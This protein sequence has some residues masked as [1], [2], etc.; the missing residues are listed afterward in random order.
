M[1]N[2]VYIRTGLPDLTPDWKE[3]GRKLEDY[4]L[5]IRELCSKKD[6]EII[7]LI[8][9]GF[10]KE[11]IG[12]EFYK[13]ATSHK[14]AFIREYFTF[15]LF[16]RNAKVRYLNN[17]LKR[18][19]EK[20]V[21]SLLDSDEVDL[22]EAFDFDEAEKLQAILEGKDILAR[23]RAIDDLYWD[24]IDQITVFHYLDFES[25]L[26]VIVKIKIIERWLKLDEKTGRE[27]FRKL[28]DEVR[29]TF[30]GVEYN[31]ESK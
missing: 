9:D 26:G 1:N 5:E 29:G 7:D 24:K 25:I 21:I 13:K 17:E 11:K 10:D 20:D 18:E 8:E 23:E 22:T 15:D 27:M 4:L 14:I 31:S 12:L 16:V 30:K 19:P 6:N 28:V 2:Y 3:N